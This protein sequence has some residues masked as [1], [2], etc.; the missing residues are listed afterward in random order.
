MSV[1]TDSSQPVNSSTRCPERTAPVRRRFEPELNVG[2]QAWLACPLHFRERSDEEG[3]HTMSRQIQFIGSVLVLF[4]FSCV[5]SLH[6]QQKPQ[7]MPGQVGL[8]AGIIPA[9]GFSYVNITIDYSS[10]AFN[11][12]NGSAI[13]VTGQL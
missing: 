6:G 1:T 11:G 10:S 13:P 7:W 3:E 12:P 4:F 9:P 5:L 2:K 8:N